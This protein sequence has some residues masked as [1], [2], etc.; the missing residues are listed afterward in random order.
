MKI[1]IQLSGEARFTGDF[2][3]FLK[4]LIGYSQADWFIYL[5]RGQSHKIGVDF[6]QS[7][8]NFDLDQAKNKIASTLPKN[9]FIQS[10][11]L[12][13]Y[14]TS[15]LSYKACITHSHRNA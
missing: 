12:T 10:F 2:N 5:S 14:L 11:E 8:E 15:S 4:N 9:N 13:N 1:A 7:W 3:L 6:S